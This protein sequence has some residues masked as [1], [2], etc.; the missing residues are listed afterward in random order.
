MRDALKAADLKPSTSVCSASRSHS[1]YHEQS[2]CTSESEM[3]RQLAHAWHSAR[4]CRVADFQ[5]FQCSGLSGS[6]TPLVA[7]VHVPRGA[8]ILSWTSASVFAQ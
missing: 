1:E 5:F 3:Y 7:V 2:L 4:H 8:F 6:S